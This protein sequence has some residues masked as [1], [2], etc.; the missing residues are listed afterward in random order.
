MKILRIDISEKKTSFEDLPEEWTLIGGRGLIA[1]IMNREVSPNTGPLGPDN[2]LIFACGPLAGTLAPQC[3]RL[4]VGAKSP[5]TM[6]IKE[7][8]AGGTSAQKLDKLG[9]RAIII[10]GAPRKGELFLIRVRRGGA[11]LIDAREH[12]EKKI[13]SLVESLFDTY[14]R[15]HSIIAIGVAGERLYR[16]ASIALTDMYGDPSR[17]AGRGGLGAVMGSKRLKALIIDGSGT[18]ALPFAD[19]E[20]FRREVREWTEAIRKDV[21]CGL[22]STCGTPFTIAL[23]SYQGT[24]PANN[25]TTGRPPGFLNVTGEVTRRKVWERNGRMHACMPG[26]VVQ[27]SIIY[28]DSEGNKTSAYEYEAVS[29][30]GTNLGIADTDR[31]ACFKHICDDI[32]VDFIEIGSALAVSSEAG[33]LRMGDPDSVLA[34]LE[35]IESDTPLTTRAR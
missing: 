17:N 1:R 10:E 20:A 24:M 30:L 29:M 14:G 35:E 6:G 15:S 28:P 11:E 3:G 8:N 25:Y 9:I 16:G 19:K 13:F 5:L 21:G 26:C 32:G 33:K 31:I 12:R 7:A 27:C 18:N 2:K 23:N 4:S 22:F 34:L